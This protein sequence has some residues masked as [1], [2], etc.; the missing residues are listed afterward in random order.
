MTQQLKF[1]RRHRRQLKQQRAP[2]AAEAARLPATPN[3]DGS[4]HTL[5]QVS[6]KPS[7]G[8]VETPDEIKTAGGKVRGS[9]MALEDF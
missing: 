5:R 8:A 3:G 2:T 1:S 7:A 4:G 6:D 9:K